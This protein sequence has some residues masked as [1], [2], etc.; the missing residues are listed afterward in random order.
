VLDI[1]RE[2]GLLLKASDNCGYFASRRWEDASK[3]VNEELLFARMLSGLVGVAVG[4]LREEG[5]QVRVVE[6]N[7]SKARPVDFSSALAR[8]RE[9][10]SE[11]PETSR[12]D[13]PPEPILGHE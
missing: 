12:T 10:Q 13:D 11:A 7:A 5:A 4:N 1:A 9:A 8:E 6:D 3:R 2:E